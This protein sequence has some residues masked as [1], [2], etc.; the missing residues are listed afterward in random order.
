MSAPEPVL[1]AIDA[2]FAIGSRWLVQDITLALHRGEV[3]ALA[4]PNGAGKS[5][6]LRLLAGDVAPTRGQVLLDGRPVGAYRPRDLALRR[7]V[8]PQQT[9]LQFAFTAKEVVEMGRSP[10]QA[11]PE[12]DEAVVLSSLQRTEALH[13]AQRPFPSLSG[14]E[15]TRVSLARVLAQETPILL[16]D[17]PTA[18]LDL[19]HQQLVMSVARAIASDGGT[20]VVVLHDLNLAAAF[21]DRIAIL[22]DGRLAAL[23]TPWDTLTESRLSEIFSCPVAVVRHPARDC[24]VVIPLGLSMAEPLDG[25][26]APGVTIAHS[27]AELPVSGI[28][29]RS[30]LTR[31]PSSR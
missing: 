13:L 28:T 21:A 17:E 20:V 30:P 24:P 4:G 12:A 8:L 11:T 26:L 3:V 15:Q 6:L 10:H 14:G 2:G 16:L 25:E 7:A 22:S 29:P 19:R 23:G 5:T 31:S 18:S 9:N 1:Q 27:E